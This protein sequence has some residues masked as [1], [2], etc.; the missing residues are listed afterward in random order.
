MELTSEEV[1]KNPSEEELK[2][3]AIKVY[4]GSNSNGYSVF[5]QQHPESSIRDKIE[6]LI[7]TTPLKLENENLKKEK[8]QLPSPE[9]FEKL[10]K[11]NQ[12][13]ENYLQD[14]TDEEKFKEIKEKIEKND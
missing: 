3:L 1:K 13:L 9:N 2:K 12:L 8:E 5:I 6:K 14:L 7:E 11:K 10:T 4:V